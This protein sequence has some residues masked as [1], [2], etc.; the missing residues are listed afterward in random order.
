LFLSLL[1]FFFLF[2]VPLYSYFLFCLFLFIFYLFFCF[3]TYSPFFFLFLFL[4]STSLSFL[5][6]FLLLFSVSFLSLFHVFVA[7]CFSFSPS[8]YFWILLHTFT[9]TSNSWL[10]F[11]CYWEPGHVIALKQSKSVTPFFEEKTLSKTSNCLEPNVKLLWC[12]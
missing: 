1:L 4:S 10:L 5:C 3:L 11:S 8:F 9:Q 12:K 7:T 6:S 2:V